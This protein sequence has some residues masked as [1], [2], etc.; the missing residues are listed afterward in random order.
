MAASPNGLSCKIG[1]SQW[2]KFQILVEDVFVT[3]D[4]VMGKASD[5]SKK[6]TLLVTTAASFLTPFMGS[7]INIALPSIGREFS[8]SA[9]LLGWVA[10]SFL[11]AAAAVLV[12][13]GKIADIWGRKRVFSIGLVVYTL[14]SFFCAVAAPHTLSSLSGCSR[15]LAEP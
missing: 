15:A 12:P 4:R 5:V 3:Q 10:Y 9:V 8:M 13:V 11:L 6:V 1:E 2:G 14:S 7:S